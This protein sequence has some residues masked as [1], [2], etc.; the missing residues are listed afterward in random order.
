MIHRITS[1]AAGLT[2][3]ATTA[4]AQA[5]DIEGTVAHI[6]PSTRTVYFTDAGSCTSNQ[7]RS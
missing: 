6:N 7:V 5:G 3:L 4:W 1:I 2:L